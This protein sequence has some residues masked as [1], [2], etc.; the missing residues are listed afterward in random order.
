MIDLILYFVRKTLLNLAL[1]LG[2]W[3]AIRSRADTGAVLS[4]W[5]AGLLGFIYL[6]LAWLSYLRSKGSRPFRLLKRKA[7]PLPPDSLRSPGYA[8]KRSP[9]L[10]RPPYPEDDSLEEDAEEAV[11]D[12][13]IRE[14]LLANALSYL[15]LGVSGLLFSMY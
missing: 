6:L 7:P 14:R 2:L 12:L 11:S 8:V 1:C 5:F 3:F 10:F 15:I 9:G 4:G 13:P